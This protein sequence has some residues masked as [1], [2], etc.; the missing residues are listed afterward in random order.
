MSAKGVRI[1]Y[2]G[3]NRGEPWCEK[4]REAPHGR[5]TETVEINENFHGL[6]HGFTC[7]A[8]GADVNQ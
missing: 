6:L 1:S 4:S 8:L 7:V 2:G 5:R 3:P